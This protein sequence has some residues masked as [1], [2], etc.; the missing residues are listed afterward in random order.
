MPPQSKLHAT[1]QR[2]IDAAAH[3]LSRKGLAGTKLTEVAAEAGT[4]AGSLYYHFKSKERLVEEVVLEGM[5]RNTEYVRTKV[6]QLGAKSSAED[7]LKAAIHAHV[8]F[9]LQGDECSRAV[10]RVYNDLPDDVRRGALSA[11]TT[12]DNMW[13]D[14]IQACQR[15]GPLNADLDLTIVRLLLLGMMKTSPDWYRPGRMSP[16]EIAG[17]VWTLFSAGFFNMAAEPVSQPAA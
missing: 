10:A 4:F 8:D 16:E 17:Q 5:N 14:L 11:Y 1:R 15:S 3:V 13:R 7:R 9:L 12:F 6:K 2:I